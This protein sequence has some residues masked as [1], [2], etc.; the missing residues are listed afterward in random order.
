MFSPRAM[1]AKGILASWFEESE[2]QNKKREK[3]NIDRGVV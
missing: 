1:V 2:D 3:E